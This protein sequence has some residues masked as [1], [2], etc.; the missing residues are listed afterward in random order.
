MT[1]EESDVAANVA[2]IRQAADAAA[3]RSGRDPRD[4]KVLAVTKTVSSGR[5]AAAVSANQ[6][7][8]GENYVQEAR[9]KIESVTSVHPEA[10]LE[11]HFIGHLQRNKSN[12]AVNLFHTLQTIDRI[13]VARA[14]SSAA[15]KIGKVQRVLLQVN[16]SEEE[17]K[18]GA[19]AG[20]MRELLK[21]SMQLRSISVDGLMCIGRYFDP[22]E[23]EELRRSEFRRMRELRDELQ[24]QEGHRLPELSMGMSHDFEAAIEE[25]ATIVR[26]G[27]AIFGDRPPQ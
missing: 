1:S 12:D 15:E 23:A 22:A 27:S 17:T 16:I 11:F 18:S 7:L 13:E 6:F 26:I 10:P 21:Q 8:F 25:G 3:I 19:S 24:Q 9:A 14:V 20:A 4:V 5:I 2:F